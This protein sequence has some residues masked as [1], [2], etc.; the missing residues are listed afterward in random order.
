V[1]QREARAS[2]RGAPELVSLEP[3]TNLLVAGPVMTGKRTLMLSL[4]ADRLA[5]GGGGV[6]VTTRKSARTTERAVADLLGRNPGENLAVVDCTGVEEWSRGRARTAGRRRLSGPGDL[7]GVGIGVTEFLRRLHADG[8][9]GV[10]GL[11]SLSTMLMYAD[12]RRLFQFV[13]VL[14][15]RVDAAGFASVVT[16]DDDVVSER[17]STVLRQAFDAV[18]EVRE[19]DGDGDGPAT[20]TAREGRG[21]PRR[22]LRVRGA[23]VGPR[24]WTPFG[25]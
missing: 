5:D 14:A 6:V 21:G 1:S 16:V 11:H 9:D 23:D 18:L 12:L 2:T 25:P 8:L 4:L 22:E 24:E 17:E 3:G 10:V 20:R 19:R 15:G 13:H 7:T